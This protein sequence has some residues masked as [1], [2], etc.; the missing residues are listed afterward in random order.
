MKN[1]FR[2]IRDIFREKTLL[3]YTDLVKLVDDGVITAKYE[4]INSA[5]IDITFDNYIM[6]ENEG[7]YSGFPDV[8]DISNKENIS[9]SEREIP[10]D[11]YNIFP[12]EFILASSAEV[13]NLPDDIVAE[14]VLK[15]SQARNGLNHLLAGYC[16]PG[17]NRSKLTLEFK[18][19]SRYHKLKI[20]AGSKAGQVKFYRVKRVPKD[21]S[22]SVVGQYNGQ[23]KVTSSKG[24][25]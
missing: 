13:F 12:D 8:I 20:R 5:S 22:Y 17:W 2:I 10:R 18:N 9:M 23:K 21:Q 1:L 25:R 24:V 3:T 15:S 11:G 7:I 6:T 4:N 16:D 19:N 14:F